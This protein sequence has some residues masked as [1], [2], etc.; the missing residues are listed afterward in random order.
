MADVTN[1]DNLVAKMDAT[2]AKLDAL[3]ELKQREEQARLAEQKSKIQLDATVPAEPG[4]PQTREFEARIKKAMDNSPRNVNKEE[5]SIVRFFRAQMAHDW[6]IAPYERYCMLKTKKNFEALEQKA[7]GWA[8][9][10]S[11]GYWVATEFLPAEFITHFVANIVCRKAGCRVIQATGAPVEIPKITAGATAY[12]V[13]QN[14]N[15]TASD[16][17]PGIL[18]LTPKF[19][20][21][22][23][24]MS[25]FL[26][27]SSEG[28]AEAIVREDLGRVLALAVDKAML[29]GNIATA[30]PNVIDG[31]ANTA[32][33]NTVAIGTNGGALTMTHL[34]SMKYKLDEDNVPEAGRCWI[35][36]PR[37]K[38]GIDKF[39]INAETNHYLFQPG[40]FQGGGVWNSL[41]QTLLGYPVYTTTQI[42]TTGSKGGGTE[43]GVNLASVFL[44]NMADIILCEWGGLSLKATDVGG[45]AWAQNA[46]EVKATYACDMGARHVDSICLLNDTTT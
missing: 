3:I 41:P 33:I 10:S 43:G 37:T 36:H 31:M 14:A 15:L 6:T 16:Q 13:G 28:A 7:I 34:H 4:D 17:T 46:I 23:T 25:E 38:S 30:T 22:R 44:V 2:Q 35:M 1:M 39:L 20:V 11:G 21:A 32:S 19:C 5:F 42:A 45:N 8:S 40:G 9:G 26:A 18:S 29:E 27:N 24:Q 12:W